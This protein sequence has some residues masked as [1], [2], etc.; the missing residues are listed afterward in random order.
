MSKPNPHKSSGQ[1]NFEIPDGAKIDS[2]LSKP[3]EDSSVMDDTG[4]GMHV[5]NVFL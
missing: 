5:I 4:K 3:F 2:I 1:V